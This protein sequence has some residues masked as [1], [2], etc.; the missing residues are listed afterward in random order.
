MVTE[1]T[2]R[3]ALRR[4]DDRGLR[5]RGGIDQ[6]G[7][8]FSTTLCRANYNQGLRCI[9]PL[10]THPAR[11][12]EKPTQLF[13]KDN[14]VCNDRRPGIGLPPGQNAQG[15]RQEHEFHTL[16]E[17]GDPE[18]NQHLIPCGPHLSSSRPVFSPTAAQYFDPQSDRVDIFTV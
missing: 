16:K 10:R 4:L 18:S 12:A 7:H 13:T 15:R 11:P 9:L 14:A 1:I 2:S 8:P 3:R 17:S 6:V 5:W